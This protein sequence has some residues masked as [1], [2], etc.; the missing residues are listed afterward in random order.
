MG[1]RL[2]QA[3]A[4]LAQEHPT[5]GDVRGIGLMVGAELIDPE[6]G[7]QAKALRDQTVDLA[8]EKG[9][10]L[11]G[12]GPSTMRFLPPLNVSAH[13]IDLAVDIFAAALDEAERAAGWA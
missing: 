7:A 10:L 5:I 1:Q 13:E 9:A 2:L 6:T 4:Q 12:A 8:Y 11:L 3:L